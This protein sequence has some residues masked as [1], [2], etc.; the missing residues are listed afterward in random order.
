MGTP[1]PFPFAKRGFHGNFILRTQRGSRNERSEC[2]QIVPLP[3]PARSAERE[4]GR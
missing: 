4:D 2:G 3:R 1:R